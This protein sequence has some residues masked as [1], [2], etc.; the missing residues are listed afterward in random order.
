MS[1]NVVATDGCPECG[2][3]DADNLQLLEDLD[4]PDDEL[5]DVKCLVCGFCYTV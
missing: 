5:Q 3:L 1:N 2:E 4:G